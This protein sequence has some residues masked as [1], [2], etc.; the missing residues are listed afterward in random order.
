MAA[1]AEV[2]F[3]KLGIEDLEVTANPAAAT[4]D[5]EVFGVGTAPITPIPITLLTQLVSAVN[6]AAAAT[7]GVALGT[8]YYSTTV[9]GLVARRT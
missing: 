6:D 7:A 4:V 5:M 9:G 3:R 1:S 8:V 2:T